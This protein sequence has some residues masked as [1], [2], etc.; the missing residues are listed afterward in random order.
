MRG[1]KSW[2]SG[3]S[4]GVE[5]QAGRA[6]NTI[7]GT[8]LL[9]DVDVDDEI[10]FMRAREEE[11][12]LHS[13]YYTV[14]PPPSRF[15]RSSSRAALHTIPPPSYSGSKRTRQRVVDVVEVYFNGSD[16]TL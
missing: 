8:A 1:R 16:T 2:V 3:S 15:T 6:S 9:V 4:K 11:Y 13:R 14:K 5:N 7:T 12:A 10:N